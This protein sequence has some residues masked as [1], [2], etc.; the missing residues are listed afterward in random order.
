MIVVG[1]YA[2]DGRW[3]NDF[4]TIDGKRQYITFTKS[5]HPQGTTYGFIFFNLSIILG[6][7]N[8]ELTNTKKT[9]KSWAIF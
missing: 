5:T 2:V 8:D 1:K 3:V 6:V 7:S 4:W 9:R